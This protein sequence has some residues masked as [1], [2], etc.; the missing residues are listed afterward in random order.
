[1]KLG[2][3]ASTGGLGALAMVV[4]GTSGLFSS[5]TADFTFPVTGGKG[6][7]TYRCQ[8]AETPE[9]SEM[10]AR[11]AHTLFEPALLESAQSQGRAMAASMS[12]DRSSSDVV[13]ELEAI[14]AEANAHR[15]EVHSE[16]QRNF[17]CVYRGSS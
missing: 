15:K 7:M 8:V 1:M 9:E 3:I 13:A 6:T 5:K 4:L 11:A 16:M 12:P 14:N 10:T 2:L 17:G